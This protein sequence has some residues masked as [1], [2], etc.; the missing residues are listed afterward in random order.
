MEACH[1]KKNLGDDTRLYKPIQVTLNPTKMKEKQ[2]NNKNDNK[3]K[4]K[5]YSFKNP[6]N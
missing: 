5:T 1:N 4:K 2:N 6:K 3:I